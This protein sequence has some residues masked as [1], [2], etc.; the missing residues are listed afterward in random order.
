MTNEAFEKWFEN[1]VLNY[2]IHDV[3]LWAWQA[4][5]A[6]S[7]QEIAELKEKLTTELKR[8]GSYKLL[9]SSLEGQLEHYRNQ[10]YTLAKARLDTLEQSLN[11]EREMNEIL[12]NEI[13]ELQAHIND[14]R[15]ALKSLHDD[16]AEYQKLNNIG[17][18]ENQ[19]MKQARQALATT[20]AQSL[21]AHDNE[22]IEKCAKVCD[23]RAKY[24]KEMIMQDVVVGKADTGAMVCAN[25]IRA[26]IE[27]E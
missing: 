3:T 8:G 16:I 21:Q 20:P 6:D 13:T 5:K 10:D 11:S 18:Y 4:A 24:M 12:T 26:L 23:D 27:K 14:L 15:E 1:T 22:V 25:A 7:E 17:G 19:C 9:V 2:N